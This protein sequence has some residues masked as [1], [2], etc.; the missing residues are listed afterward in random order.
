MLF[1]PGLMSF[2]DGADVTLW[3]MSCGGLVKNSESYVD[4]VES[5]NRSV[6]SVC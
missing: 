3:M 4:L 6:P 1:P 5:S 2:L